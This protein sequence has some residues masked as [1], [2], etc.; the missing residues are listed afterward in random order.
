MRRLATMSV[1]PN[2]M[3]RPLMYD[4]LDFF[5]RTSFNAS[6]NA[7]WSLLRSSIATVVRPRGEVSRLILTNKQRRGK[8]DNLHS[9]IDLQVGLTTTTG[10]K[11][12]RLVIR[13]ASCLLPPPTSVE[14]AKAD[15]D[16]D[17]AGSPLPR[18][19]DSAVLVA[20][21]AAAGTETGDRDAICA[22]VAATTAA[23]V[24]A[25]TAMP[26]L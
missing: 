3:L 1:Q 15:D 9:L 19:H 13:P 14:E 22:A 25:M 17:F 10:T 21:G 4:L 24:V 20:S 18:V 2:I 26:Y 16:S 8:T 23:A 11:R 12:L 6:I 7:V 5:T